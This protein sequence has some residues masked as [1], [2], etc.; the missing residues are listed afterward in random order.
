M[1]EIYKHNDSYFYSD[2]GQGNETF[3]LP[4]EG[5]PNTDSFNPPRAP[6]VVELRPAACVGTTPEE[7]DG[8]ALV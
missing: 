1:I 4:T 2:T 6:P 7:G 3:N 5:Y 8:R